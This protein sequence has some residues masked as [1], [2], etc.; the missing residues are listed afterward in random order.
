[1]RASGGA[2]RLAVLCGGDSGERGISLN[3]ARSLSDHL[4]GTGIELLLVYYDQ[5]LSP[6]EISRPQL[7]SNTPSDFDFK[8]KN[9][10]TALD[11]AALV[12]LLKGCDLVFPAMHGS[13]GED[14]QIQ[15]FL[16]Q[17]GVPHVGMSAESCRSCFHKGRAYEAMSR[18]GF[19]VL[20]HVTVK[21]SSTPLDGESIAP[22][23]K[24]R[25][26]S[27]LN[28]PESGKK[29]IVKPCSTGSSI[30]VYVA[31][32]EERV[33]AAIEEIF[34]QNIDDEIIVEPF[35]RGREFS[36]IIL[37]EGDGGVA[38]MPTEV[39]IIAD[40]DG[41][42]DFR[43]K[44]LSNSQTR[45]HTPPRISD[46]ICSEETVSAIR[47]GASRLFSLFQM[48]DFARIDGWLTE[49]GELYFTDINP[50]SGMEQNSFLFVQ[51]ASVGMSHREILLSLLE[52]S[53]A[54]HGIPF[55][56]ESRRESSEKE[57]IAILF[58]G[59]TAE[60]NVSIASGTNVWLK[61]FTSS[62]Y[63]P[64]PYFLSD[65]NTVW[66]VPYSFALHHTAEEI[67]S[68][69]RS[70]AEEEPRRAL[71]R[72]EI[73]RD[74]GL[75]AATDSFIASCFSL[76]EFLSSHRLVFSTLHGG[77]GENGVLQQIF[78][79]AGVSYVGCGPEASAICADKYETAKRLA[80]KEREGIFTAPKV[81][82]DTDE[83]LSA[84]AEELEGRWTA[85]HKE[86]SGDSKESTLIVKPADDGCSAG[87][88]RLSGVSDLRRY[89]EALRRRELI[90]PPKTFLYQG[91]PIEMP[92]TLPAALLFETFIV[93]DRIETRGNEIVL[94][95]RTGLVEVTVGI[96][97]PQHDVHAMNPS[98]TIAG[99]SVL[100]LEEK[101]QGG[102]GVNIT[103]PPV[104]LVSEEACAAARKRIEIVA[105]TLGLRGISRIDA[106]LN[107]RNGEITVIEV[108]T[109]PGLTP[110]TV[111]YHQAL[112]EQPPLY[113]REFLEQVLENRWRGGS[114]PSA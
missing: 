48:S 110:S 28:S 90:L 84:P 26:R 1:M 47:T 38:L 106:F 94:E 92:T 114:N 12:K 30:G 24:E 6:Y 40:D 67:E 33:I 35:L 8:L 65:E 29:Y 64:N 36:V 62:H 98:I 54:R 32:S 57:E 56:R 58:G 109:L 46:G 61:L 86:L 19:P 76:E 23:E 103:P 50:I 21:R 42:F 37:G 112:E 17:H 100:S 95:E 55:S 13:F 34:E 104:E 43:R 10:A 74:L 7:Y 89:V 108:N 18:F 73:R 70:S 25:L 51:A 20:P 5:F 27:F 91:G 87:V 2:L 78:E 107:R 31:E 53:C 96:S 59:V 69:C 80:G 11:E 52:R 81:L 88:V 105:N 60:R 63:A 9:I 41:L 75:E 77:I 39:E 3:S 102:T 49:D 14:G 71:L 82:M 16:E 101:F 15:S 113:P 83:L 66:K 93:T 68:L 72:A 45:Y 97:G 99:G 4:E 22:A 44:Y 111:I 85:L 79:K